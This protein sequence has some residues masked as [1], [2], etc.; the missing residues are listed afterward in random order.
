MS[1][2]ENCAQRTKSYINVVSPLLKNSDSGYYRVY[3]L[4]SAPFVIAV[5]KVV[6]IISSVGINIFTAT[7]IAVYKEDLE[8]DFRLVIMTESAD[9][10]SMS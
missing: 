6:N 8:T 3:Q 2:T 4:L 1:Y 9:F 10:L 7:I 5:R